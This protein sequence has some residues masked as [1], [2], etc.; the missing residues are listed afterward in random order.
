MK[1]PTQGPP[2]LASCCN[3]LAHAALPSDFALLKE[4]QLATGHPWAFLADVALSDPGSVAYYRYLYG[5]ARLLNPVHVLEIGTAFGLGSAAFL[6]GSPGLRKL[7]SLDL[8]VF[9]KQY[10]IVEQSAGAGWPVMERYKEEQLVSDGRNIDFAR[11]ALGRLAARTRPEAQVRIYRV[12]TQPSG[13]DNFDVNV[14]VPRWFEVPELVAEL[15]ANPVDLLFIDGKHTGDGLYQDFKS[16][17]RFLRPGG[18]VLCDDVHDSSYPY[19]WAGQTLA[20]FERATA[21]FAS[22]IEEST[23]WTFAQL[24]DWYGQEPI[25]RPFGLVRKKGS[26]REQAA[27][28]RGET[29][30]VLSELEG[31][32][33]DDD[34]IR[35][36]RLLYRHPAFLGEL[37]TL[38]LGDE[39]AA[40]LLNQIKRHPALLEALAAVQPPV[41]QLL[42][43]KDHASA[44][45]LLSQ[46]LPLVADLEAF[47][48]ESEPTSRG[49]L[50]LLSFLFRRAVA[51]QMGASR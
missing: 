22:E 24:P 46:R 16:F 48:G 47:Q 1:D 31:L 40:R 33:S 5:L 39:E 49:T 34:L 7:T 13:S 42:L 44:L 10:E 29:A 50:A 3:R 36:L 9:T 4:A 37:A 18:V 43:V 20:S 25:A 6:L 15:Q 8:G 2:D 45:A 51:R 23:I 19:Q 14:D 17:F 35:H 38:S 27:L 30:F 21:E 28:P 41:E 32:T 12:N 11:E 26:S